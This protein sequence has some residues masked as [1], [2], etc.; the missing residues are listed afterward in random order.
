MFENVYALANNYSQNTSFELDTPIADIFGSSTVNAY[1]SFRKYAM[2]GIVQAS[3]LTGIGSAQPPKFSMYFDEFGTIM[4]E[5]ALFNFKYDLAYPALYAELSPTFNN[6]KGYAVSG[7]RASSYGAEFLIFNTTDSTLNLDETS[8]NYLRVQGIAFTNQSP[9][10][11]T[12]DEYFSKNSDLS[13]PE[14]DSTGIIT[15]VNRV[16][17][18]YQ[19]IKAS[20]MLYGK[21]DFSLDVPYIQSRDDAEVLMSWLVNKIT[22]PRKSIGIKIFA[23]PMIQLGDIVKIDY[24]EKGINK[25]ENEDSRFVVYNI[26]YAKTK[27]GP[28][29]SVFLSEVL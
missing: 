11:F 20:R 28:E 13:N 23:N 6:L 14:F 2:S 3:Y 18:N 26:E 24:V 4:R 1:D 7:F 5:A 29:M 12:V 19:D 15:P 27:D 16:A 17:K 21:K 9:N 25:I 22:K 10:N 8:Q